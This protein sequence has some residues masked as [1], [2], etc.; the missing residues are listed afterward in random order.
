MPAAAWAQ[1][2]PTA[3]LADG[4]A[5]A[6]AQRLR[7][8]LDRANADIDALKAGPRGVRTDY[9]LRQRMADAEAVA[10]RLTDLEAKQGPGAAPPSEVRPPRVGPEPTVAPTDG[11]AELEAKADILADQS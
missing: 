6:E 2:A 3:P 8:E 10:R 7:A 11:P 4:R 9:L 5:S 1:V